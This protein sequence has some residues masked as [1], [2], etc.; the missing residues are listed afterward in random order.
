MERSHSRKAGRDENKE[1]E[2]ERTGRQWMH[3]IINRMSLKKDAIKARKTSC[4]E[5]MIGDE[6]EAEKSRVSFQLSPLHISL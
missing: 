1:K 5:E 4:E 3:A 2:N 6:R